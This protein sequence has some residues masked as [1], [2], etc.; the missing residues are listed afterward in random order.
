MI[1]SSDATYPEF[2]SYVVEQRG[3]LPDDELQDLWVWR[4]KLLGVR[5]TTGR[6][7]RAL[8][9]LDEQDLTMKQREQKLLSEARAQGKDP[10]YVG[11]RWV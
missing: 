5:M 3:S 4:Q 7:M 11:R 6:A 9:P 10:V 1:L 2:C 8:L